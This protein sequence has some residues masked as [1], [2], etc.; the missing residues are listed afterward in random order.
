MGAIFID[1]GIQKVLDV[2]QH[3]LS[4]FIL[5]TANFSKQRFNEPKD[6]FNKYSNLLMI[7]PVIWHIKIEV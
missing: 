7:K 2:Y 4:P 3:F 5:F 1:G 6:D